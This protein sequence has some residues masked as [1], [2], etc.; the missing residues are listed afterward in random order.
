M[1]G[2]DNNLT[3]EKQKIEMKQLVCILHY[4]P[5]CCFSTSQVRILQV[6]VGFWCQGIE[7]QFFR[8]FDTSF[9]TK[10]MVESGAIEIIL[11]S[12]EPFQS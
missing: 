1:V 10:M 4:T 6:N 9:D 8:I 12:H 5:I 7:K 2:I 3:R 11:K